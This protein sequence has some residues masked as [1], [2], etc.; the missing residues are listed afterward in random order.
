MSSSKMTKHDDLE[1]YKVYVCLYV[2]FLYVRSNY[3]VIIFSPSQKKIENSL[4][5][6]SNEREEEEVCH[7]AYIRTKQKVNLYLNKTPMQHPNQ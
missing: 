5:I 4:K 6:L 3:Y 2:F 1:A 7:V